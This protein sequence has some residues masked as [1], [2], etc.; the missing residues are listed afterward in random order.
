MNLFKKALELHQAG[1]YEEAKNIYQQLLETN[2]EDA[3]LLHVYGILLAQ[4][5]DFQNAVQ[6]LENALKLEPN[7]STFHNSMGNALWHMEKYPEAIQHYE[8]SIQLQP[9][10][11]VAHNNLGNLYCK[12]NRYDKA[13]VHYQSAIALKPDYAD[14]YCNLAIAQTQ[15]GKK[16]EAIY[17]LQRALI[18]QVNHVGA[19][20]LLAQLLHEKGRTE[21]AFDHYKE[22]L[23]IDPYHAETYVNMG[24]I[25]VKQG[26]LLEAI[27]YF[28]KALV[29]DPEHAEAHY[30]LGSTFLSLQDA[31]QALVHYLRALKNKP[32]SDTYYNIGVIYMY[33]DR[34]MDAIDYFNTAVQLRPDYFEAYVNLGSVY[35]KLENYDLAIKNFNTAL[36]IQPENLEIQYILSAISEQSQK[37]SAAPSDFVKHL[38]DQYAP[39]FEK[40][41]LE[42]LNYQAH[43]LIHEY[44]KELPELKQK[45]LR[46]VDLGCGTGLCGAL[47]RPYASHLIGVDISPKMIAIS[48]SKHIYDQ[49]ITADLTHA[50]KT[51]ADSDIILAA[52]VFGY[53]GDL[54]LV[55]QNIKNAL[56][57]GGYFIFT[58]EK[59]DHFPYVLQKSARYAHHENYIRQIAQAND[60]EIIKCQ[61]VELRK[62][63]QNPV[64]GNL[65]I[66]QRK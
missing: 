7:S 60:F 43:L 64:V 13:V 11:A 20:S 58:V 19:H 56:K 45:N 39:Y 16:E 17:N 5:G 23:K 52:D 38:F 40:H 1:N 27:E 62:Q 32:D 15:I 44:A 26:K 66:L 24:G 41:L 25:L 65:F 33:K 50:L 55:F 59:T 3:D 30:N 10:S 57:P 22:R 31:D 47:F 29:I 4:I 9:N 53:M 63:K 36:S 2:P 54:E 8:R 35:L 34:H 42:C 14:A 37:P 61:E 28:D 21:D 18:E 51:L 12:I 48:E 46:I 49:L 6:Y